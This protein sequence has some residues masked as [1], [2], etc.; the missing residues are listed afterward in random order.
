MGAP[1][2]HFEIG[3]RD[4]ARSKA[5][6]GELFGWKFAEFAGVNMID[7]DHAHSM[8]GHFNS[9]GHEPHNYITIY[10]TVDDVQAYIDRATKLG[11]KQLVPPTE[12]PGA[13]TFAW[14]ADPDGT[15]VGLW[16]DATPP[17]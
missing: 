4:I 16:K 3:C 13:G 12:V 17:A 15:I 7:P 14:I 11:G 9:L 10:M 2:M 6:Y 1:V 8:R 5:F